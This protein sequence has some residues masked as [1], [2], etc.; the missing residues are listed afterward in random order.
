MVIDGGYTGRINLVDPSLVNILVGKGY[1][2][3]IS[4]IAL[5]NEFDFLNVDGDRGSGIYCGWSKSAVSHFYNKR[6]WLD[7]R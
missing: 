7:I 2:P 4:P 3:V 5:S 6:K 1:V